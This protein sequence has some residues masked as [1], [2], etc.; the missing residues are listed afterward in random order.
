VAVSLRWDWRSR[1]RHLVAA[2]LVAALVAGGL[3]AAR[4]DLSATAGGATANQRLWQAC[5][6]GSPP[7]LAAA[8]AEGADPR[9]VN[10]STGLPPLLEVLRAAAGPL[11]AARHQCI[12]TLLA[13]GA[14]ADA[15]DRD[16]RTAVIYAT[17][18]GDLDT[19]R[20]LVEAEAFVRTRDRF[21]KTA[22]FYAVEANR[23][24]IVRYLTDN[25]ALISL[26][27]RERKQMARR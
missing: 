11:D 24:D 18:L 19:L 4:E 22:L 16:E 21:H 13:H 12:S 25:G 5:E 3:A 6:R 10:P 15:T 27:V 7:A 9:Q 20:V 17:R 26:S 23:R 14:N 8:L 1:C 2:L